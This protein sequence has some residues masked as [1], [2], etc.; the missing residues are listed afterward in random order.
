M[1][2]FRRDRKAE[3]MKLTD[4][5]YI[6]ELLAEGGTGFKKKLGQNFLTSERVLDTIADNACEGVL[7]IGPG[8]GTL[9]EKLCERAKRVVSIEIDETL[10]P[11]LERTLG[12]RDN[13]R[14]VNADAL[15]VDLAALCEE[16]FGGMTRSVC[17]NLPYY[18]T[19]PVLTRLLECGAGFS[20][21]TVMVQ[22]EV[23]ARLCAAPGSADYGAITVFCA[24][25][26]SARR[27]IKVP[28]G[29]FVPAPK[30]DSAVV[31]IDMHEKPPADCEPEALFRTVRA[32]FG[33]RR[34]T[35]A[36]ALSAG[37]PEKGRG[38]IATALERC[39]IPAS[40]RGEQLS[41]ADFARLS[42]ALGNG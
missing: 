17:A 29:C 12:G 6:K 8:I 18:V 5:S 41:L 21:V 10:I 37:F 26:G 20:N 11:I 14:I 4:V 34:K 15:K 19:T 16:E 42:D 38:D 23:A 31:R 9:T 7:E 24:Y 33:Q 1:L 22:K 27:V 35:L 40:A 25:Y 3:I 28:A 2:F 39:G 30:V 13:L 32:A 36:N